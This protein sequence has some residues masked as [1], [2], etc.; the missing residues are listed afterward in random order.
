M[1]KH[2]LLFGTLILASLV[3]CGGGGGGGNAVPPPPPPPPANATTLAY[4]DPVS[5]PAGAFQFKKA[6]SQGGRL[7]LELHGPATALRGSGIVLTLNV[8]ATKAAWASLGPDLVT[9]GSVLS[10]GSGTP[11]LKG[12]ASGGTLQVAIAEKGLA[13]AKVLTGPLLQ[14]ALELKTGVA[15]NTAI[16][17]TVDLAKS[18]VLLADG[19]LAPVADLKF[20][21]L[22]A[23]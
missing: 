8:D 16:V 13:S 10:L 20:G 6:S 9:P 19:T 4:T 1:K 12:K 15:A 22:T 5:V 11:I 3:A 21:T 2:T 23:Q 18:K 7:V 14:V 17:P